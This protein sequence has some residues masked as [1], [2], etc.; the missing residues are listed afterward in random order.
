MPGD[1][2]RLA[3]GKASRMWAPIDASLRSTAAEMSDEDWY[4]GG[5]EKGLSSQDVAHCQT[6]S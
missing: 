5:H 4:E 2:V 3:G 1:F 6:L